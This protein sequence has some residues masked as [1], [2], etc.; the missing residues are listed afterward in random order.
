MSGRFSQFTMYCNIEMKAIKY[1]INTILILSSPPHF[2]FFF[3]PNLKS[4]QT[5][6]EIHKNGAQ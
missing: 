6:V 3:L 4:R 2:F 1:S 5:G